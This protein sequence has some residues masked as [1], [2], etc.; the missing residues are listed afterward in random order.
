MFPGIRILT[1]HG[2]RPQRVGAARRDVH[3]GVRVAHAHRE[4]QLGAGAEAG[5]P[6]SSPVWLKHGGV[7][8][9]DNSVIQKLFR[10]VEQ[11]RFDGHS[12]LLILLKDF[13]SNVV[14]F[15]LLKIMKYYYCRDLL[16]LPKLWLLII[17]E[18]FLF[19]VVRQS[20]SQNV[21]SI[22]HS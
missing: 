19:S 1:S 4:G 8:G 20:P 5:Q 14:L 21:L 13:F 22:T 3:Q 15:W 9:Q 18:P 17:V 11:T 12:N 6:K 10:W 2:L 7:V 16:S